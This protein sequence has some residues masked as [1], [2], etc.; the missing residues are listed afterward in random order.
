MMLVGVTV[1]TAAAA[2]NDVDAFVSPLPSRSLSPNE[3][4][5]D[6]GDEAEYE[7]TP[8]QLA[9]PSSSSGAGAGRTRPQQQRKKRRPTKRPT[10]APAVIV[11]SRC[12]DFRK[13]KVLCCGGRLNVLNGLCDNL[14]VPTGCMWTKNKCLPQPPPPG[15]CS[16]QR[17]GA[18]VQFKVVS[19]TFSFWSTN[20]DF[21]NEAMRLHSI[22]ATR[23]PVL[24]L[25]NGT[26]CDAQ[27]DYRPED[28]K[29]SF[30]DFAPIGCNA[31]PSQI[32]ANWIARRDGVWCPYG[33][34]GWRVFDYRYVDDRR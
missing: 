25:E 20:D 10:T 4:E 19:A 2:L 30:V 7:T 23:I 21:I 27:W 32:N 33:A 26:G 11:W 5:V 3:V 6:D 8:P 29:M 12:T 22:G 13:S 28:D 34:Y 14:R 31:L 16:T 1:T 24:Q 9:V 17:G 18:I 15:P